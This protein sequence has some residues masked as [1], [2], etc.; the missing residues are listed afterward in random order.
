MQPMKGQRNSVLYFNGGYKYRPMRNASHDTYQCVQRHTYAK[1]RAEACEY[2]DGSVQVFGTHT[3]VGD[4]LGYEKYE[5]IEEMKKRARETTDKLSIIF[6]D[7]CRTY[8]N[9]FLITN[10]VRSWT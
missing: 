3:C 8:V 1:C 10:I 6:K 4:P 2:E 5:L 9:Y 7:V